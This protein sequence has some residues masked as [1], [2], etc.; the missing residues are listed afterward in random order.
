MSEEKRSEENAAFE[1]LAQQLACPDGEFGTALAVK[2]NESN[3]TMTALVTKELNPQEGQKILEIGL[4]NGLLSLPVIEA[5]GKSGAF[6]AVEKS[7]TLAKAA[8]KM[9]EQKGHK[10]AYVKQGDFVGSEIQE[11]IIDG[12]YC[13]N[14]LYF[15]DDLSAFFK[16]VM[17]CL[18]DGGKVVI[19]VRSAD[20]LR[21][22]PFTQYGFIIRETQT[23]E[24]AMRDAGF[25][26]V[27]SSFHIEGQVELNDITFDVDSV[28]FSAN[29]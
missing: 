1:M 10:N 2:M 18:V 16:H 14:V 21:A 22:M 7:Q 23:I 8:N 5:I 12:L 9:F 3:I 15:I 6:L 24:Q 29:K 20:S 28:I 13:V 4:G 17:S 11:N 25:N 27:T 26:N 19:G